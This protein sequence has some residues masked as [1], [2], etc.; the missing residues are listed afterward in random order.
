MFDDVP[1]FSQMAT[2]LVS[3]SLETGE[4]FS[5]GEVHNSY[6]AILDQNPPL[7]MGSTIPECDYCSRDLLME[8][9]HLDICWL[10]TL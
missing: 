5:T 6:R 7:S 9:E 1:V 4:P 3:D 2:Y 10:P 8:C